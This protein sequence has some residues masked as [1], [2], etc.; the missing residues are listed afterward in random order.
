[1]FCCLWTLSWIC[2]LKCKQFWDG[3][4]NQWWRFMNK[5]Q[6]ICSLDNEL[7]INAVKPYW[8]DIFLNAMENPM[9]PTIINK[10]PFITLIVCNNYLN[11][12][13]INLFWGLSSFLFK[14]YRSLIH[15]GFFWLKMNNA[16]SVF[17]VYKATS[18]Y[19]FR[20]FFSN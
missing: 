8:L 13:A 4:R 3:W 15:F 2:L 18:E 14:C 5:F 20:I 9:K 16:L 6:L 10:Q 12:T 7:E 11:Y 17:D 1:M 19:S